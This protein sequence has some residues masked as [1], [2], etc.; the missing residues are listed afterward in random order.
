MK[1]I[2]EHI[3]KNEFK[4]VY[5]IYGEE[6]YLRKQY[7]DRLKQAVIGDDTMNYS[8]FEGDKID[9]KEI[10]DTGNTLPFFSERRLIIVEN[11]GFFKSANDALADFIRSI[12]DYLIMVFVEAEVDKRNKVYKACSSVGYVCEMKH[13]SDSVLIRWITGMFKNEGKSISRE[14]CMLMLDKTGASMEEI[15]SEFNKLIGYCMDKNTVEAEDVEAICT[16]QTTSRIFDMIAAIASRKKDVALS[17]YYDLL[18]LKEPPMRIL[19]LIVRQFNGILQ[20]KEALSE[21]K[22]NSEI[23]RGM[24]VA[25]FIV[26]KYATQSKHFSKEQIKGALQDFADIEERVKTGLLNDKLGIEMMIVKYGGKDEE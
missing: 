3:K 26:G 20:V 23:A 17:L 22:S 12:P 18:A 24:G 10:I 14:A 19:Y 6:S 13:Q 5:L 11:S 21:G 9:V 7:K 1:I 2:N 25:P 4:N 15:H 8:Y 16:T